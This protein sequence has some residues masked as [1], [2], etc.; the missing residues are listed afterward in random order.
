[1]DQAAL[2]KNHV[3]IFHE[4]TSPSNSHNIVRRSIVRLSAGEAEAI[5]GLVIP[6]VGAKRGEVE[7]VKRDVGERPSYADAAFDHSSIHVPTP[8][9]IEPPTEF[10]SLRLAPNIAL[11]G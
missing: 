6:C 4:R 3:L 11:G 5:L 10:V 8:L 1:M 7:A 9:S 2:V